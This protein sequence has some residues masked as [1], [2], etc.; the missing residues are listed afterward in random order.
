MSKWVI[1]MRAN[2]VTSK[3]TDGLFNPVSDVTYPSCQFI[4]MTFD[5]V[6]LHQ[7]HLLLPSDMKKASN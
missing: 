6:K 3:F 4:V 7:M 2:Y 5:P 1:N